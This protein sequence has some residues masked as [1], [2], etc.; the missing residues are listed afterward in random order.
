[1]KPLLAVMLLA[2]TT[3]GCAV[4]R[5][6]KLDYAPDKGLSLPTPGANESVMVILRPARTA[7]GISSIVYEDDQFISIVM[8]R[9]HVVH[10]TTPGNHRYMVISESAD[11][12]DADLEGGKIY[13]ARAVPRMGAWRARFSLLPITPDSNEWKKL[14]K[15]LDA[16]HQVTPNDKGM[17][18]ADDNR[19]SVMSKKD[20]KLNGWLQ[21]DQRPILTPEDG[22]SSWPPGS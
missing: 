20:G 11:F 1:M 6:A 18:W 15:W 12:M 2:V 3:T 16:S 21:K 5:N 19:P 13:F 7:H 4:S 9:S 17:Q 22:V 8:A 14:A 10:R